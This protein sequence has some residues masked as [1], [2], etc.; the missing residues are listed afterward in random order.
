MD[1]NLLTHFIKNLPKVRLL[2]CFADESEILWPIDKVL[3]VALILRNS[4]WTV[5]A[6]G[7]KDNLFHFDSSNC[8]RFET[9]GPFCI[10]FCIKLAAA[11]DLRFEKLHCQEQNLDYLVINFL[12]EWVK[13]THY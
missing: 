7:K 9:C 12:N 2:G 4:H 13:D 5:V 10:F 11:G 3:C 6:R 1:V 8:Q